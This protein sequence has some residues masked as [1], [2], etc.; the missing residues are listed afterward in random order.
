MTLTLT[1]VLRE[2][3]QWV[4]ECLFAFVLEPLTHSELSVNPS[5]RE[6][7]PDSREG[8]QMV[9]E[10]LDRM[11]LSSLPCAVLLLIQTEMVPGEWY[12]GSQELEREDCISAQHLHFPRVDLTAFQDQ[13]KALN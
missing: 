9:Q 4:G 12:L 5:N 8:V 7:S 3:G 10:G 2:T 1:I 6:G 13:C 11:P